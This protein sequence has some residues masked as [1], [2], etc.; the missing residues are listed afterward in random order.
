MHHHHHD[1]AKALGVV[2]PGYSRLVMHLVRPL[3][4]RLAHRRF[5]QMIGEADADRAVSIRI[6]A[7]KVKLSALGKRKRRP[8]KAAWRYS[9]ANGTRSSDQDAQGVAGRVD[10]GQRCRADAITGKAG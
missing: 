4:A 10:I 1:D 8:T 6:C 3:S 9:R 5:E 7:I 2:D